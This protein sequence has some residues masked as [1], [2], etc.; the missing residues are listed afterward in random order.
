MAEEKSQEA[1]GVGLP[2]G[3][4]VDAG[5][6]KSVPPN[7][8]WACGE[9]VGP[10]YVVMRVYRPNAKFAAFNEVPEL[11]KLVRMHHACHRAA[12]I[13]GHDP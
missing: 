10:T 1:A 6:S 2:G 12:K 13:V 7:A 8:C 4:P 5:A 3:S 11:P 9:P